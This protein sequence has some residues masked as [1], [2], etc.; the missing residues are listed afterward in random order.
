MDSLFEVEQIRRTGNFNMDTDHFHDFYE[1]YYLLSGE[2]HYYIHNRIYALQAGDLVFINKNELHRTTSRNR[3]PHERIL[4]SF[5]GQFLRPVAGMDMD[6]MRLFGGESFLLR[7]TAHEQGELAELFQVMLQE[8]R[9]HQLRSSLYL[10]TLL[11]QL[12]IRLE[13]IREAKPSV[14]N[15]EQ[16]EG[17]RRVYDIIEYLDAH[18]GEK[19]T[20]GGIAEHF[21]ISTP[22]LC[23]TFKQ[24]TGFTVVE[25]L[26]YVRIRE[27]KA[28]LKGTD[29]KVTRIARE[30]GF[31]SIAHFGRVFKSVTGRTP[32]Q[33]RKQNRG[34]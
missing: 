1:I 9:D 2:R 25:Y 29:W 27:T 10:Q 4:I 22:Y 16:S 21:F 23:R 12:L 17:Q 28:L 26:N 18:Y 14:V 31:E 13:R 19:L 11:L 15:P 30:M 33:Y 7:P 3:S 34:E 8:Q 20:L 6:W 32:L 5:D 24:T